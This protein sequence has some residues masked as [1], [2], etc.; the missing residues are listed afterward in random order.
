M[1]LY[2][3][4]D[5]KVC[6]ELRYKKVLERAEKYLI[7]EKTLPDITIK[8]TEEQLQAVVQRFGTDE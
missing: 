7:N 5:L 3:I 2:N 6:M 1:S 4:A 8:A